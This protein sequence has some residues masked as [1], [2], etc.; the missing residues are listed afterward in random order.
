MAPAASSPSPRPTGATPTTR[1]VARVIYV[2]KL[3]RIGADFYRVVKQIKTILGAKPLV[4]VL[5]IGTEGDFVGVV[6]LLTRKAYVWDDTGQPENF[7]IE[8]VPADMKDKVEKYRAELIETAVEQDDDVHGEVPRRRRAGHRARSRSASARARSSWRSS[9]PTAAPRSRTRA[10]STFSTPSSTTCRTRPRS[11]P[12]PEVDLEG[13]PTGKFAIV[14]PTKPVPRAGV[15]DHGRPLRQPDLHPHLLGHDQ[16]GRCRAQHLHRQDRA[17]RPHGR[18]A[19][20]RPH[21]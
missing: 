4:M 1:K 11:Q 19:R 18:D 17:H 12:Q 14:D 6:D 20:Q 13:N 3:D 2:N 16:E 8:D 7:K 9:R 15:Q 5:P 10:C 21:R